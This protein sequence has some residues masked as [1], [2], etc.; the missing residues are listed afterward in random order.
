MLPGIIEGRNNVVDGLAFSPDGKTVAAT[1]LL[2]AGDKVVN[3][4]DVPSR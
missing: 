3:L 1:S 4:W 2:V